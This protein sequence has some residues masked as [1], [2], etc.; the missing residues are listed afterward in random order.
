MNF[1]SIIKVLFVLIFLTIFFFNCGLEEDDN[2]APCC[3]GTTSPSC[4]CDGDLQ[5]CCSHHGGV[6]GC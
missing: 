2:K 1:K 4:Y 3:D 6:C 5:G